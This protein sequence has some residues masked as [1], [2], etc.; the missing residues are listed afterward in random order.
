[1]SHHFTTTKSIRFRE[2]YKELAPKLTVKILSDGF[3]YIFK[4]YWWNLAILYA[5]AV[6]LE[7]DFLK[8]VSKF[9]S[10]W[11]NSVA[12]EFR[13]PLSPSFSELAFEVQKRFFTNK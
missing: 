1:M 3:G 10:N 7:T 5:W 12:W 8:F 2:F 6:T 4:S 13:F 11:L 9:A